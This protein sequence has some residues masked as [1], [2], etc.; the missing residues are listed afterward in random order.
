MEAFSHKKDLWV[1]EIAQ[2][3]KGPVYKADG[4]SFIPGTYTLQGESQLLHVFS[5]LCVCCGMHAH[6]HKLT[7][8]SHSEFP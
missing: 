5:G 1:S 2:W 6:A 8:F 4:L 7:F 3:L